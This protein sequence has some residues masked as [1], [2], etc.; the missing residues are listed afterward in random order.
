[1]LKVNKV[2]VTVTGERLAR[3]ESENDSKDSRDTFGYK[4]VEDGSDISARFESLD[5]SPI[6]SDLIGRDAGFDTLIEVTNLDKF[7]RSYPGRFA[8]FILE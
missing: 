2:F 5:E 3:F 4:L 8:I 1:M 7:K 6:W